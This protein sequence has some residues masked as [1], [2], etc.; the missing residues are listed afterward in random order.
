MTR[1]IILN[2][3][4]DKL[5][6]S[7][8]FVSSKKWPQSEGRLNVI[9]ILNDDK[10]SDDKFKPLS[11]VDRFSEIYIVGHYYPGKPGIYNH[12]NSHCFTYEWISKLLC[13][14]IKD[15]DICIRKNADSYMYSKQLSIFMI[16]CHTGKRTGI[17]KKQTS[18]AEK[19]FIA[20][21]NDEDNPLAVEIHA[22]KMFVYPVPS[23][24][25]EFK[26]S[27]KELA[28]QPSYNQDWHLRYVDAPYWRGQFSF[29]KGYAFY[30]LFCPSVKPPGNYKQII[31][32][33]I[34][35]SSGYKVLTLSEHSELE[36]LFDKDPSDSQVLKDPNPAFK[37]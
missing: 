36:K 4:T 22:S 37:M 26:R 34:N 8:Q 32:R 35:S 21:M 9:H 5:G 7:L 28:K 30:S 31:R 33:E 10:I 6:L 27:S 25:D 17:F 15:E 3:F 19:L 1:R 24:E 13:C 18:L 16:A 29:R 23:S 2:F 14:N 11:D 12:D 20:L